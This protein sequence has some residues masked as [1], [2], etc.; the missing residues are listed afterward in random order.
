[1]KNGLWVFLVGIIL[2][3]LNA[4]EKD[5]ICVANDTPKLILQFY[6]KNDTTQTK[7]VNG[8]SV[9]GLRLPSDTL[10]LFVLSEI[11]TSD[12][13]ALP[14]N[15]AEDATVFLFGQ[16]EEDNSINYDQSNFNY[17]INEVFISRACGY[18]A[19]YQQL[20]AQQ[21]ADT[22]PWISSIEIK[23]SSI[24]DESHVHVKIFH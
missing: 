12:S 4:C 18:I 21:I 10:D 3:S 16:E 6:D 23:E 8:L 13:I 22:A 14:L 9:R 7:E 2:G 17:A 5:D 24:T 20:T 11:G 15:S 1:M 19:N